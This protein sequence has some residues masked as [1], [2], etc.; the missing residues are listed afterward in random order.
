MAA[1]SAAWA[2]NSWKI[3]VMRCGSRLTCSSLAMIAPMTS[4]SAGE[5]ATMRLLVRSSAL[6]RTSMIGAPS[7]V[8][9]TRVST[10]GRRPPAPPAVGTAAPVVVVPRNIRVR[11]LAT[12]VASEFFRVKTLT[13][14]ANC[15]GTSMSLI[16]CKSITIVAS[17]AE[18]SRLLVRTSG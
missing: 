11:M 9:P 5:A 3:W 7:G 2:L 6:M 15:G 13:V 16:R 10:E 14:A 17:G 1:T 12:S 8:T 18:M 4:R